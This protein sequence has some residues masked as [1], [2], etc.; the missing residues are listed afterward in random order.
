MIAREKN[1]REREIHAQISLAKKTE[2]KIMAVLLHIYIQC[3]VTSTWRE[4]ERET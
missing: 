4:R 2:K 1:A 3:S